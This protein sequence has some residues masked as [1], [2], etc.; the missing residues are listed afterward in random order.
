[1]QNNNSLHKASK[2][3]LIS[4]LTENKAF[5]SYSHVDEN[6]M[7][8][9]MLI[10]KTFVHLDIDDI[11][12]MFSIYPYSKIKQVW[13]ERLVPQGDHYRK[14]NRLLAWMYFDIKKPDRYLNRM[15]NQHNKKLQRHCRNENGSDAS[16]K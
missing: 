16:E 7:P 10:E 14:L 11:N 1:M 5:W 15:I 9:E 6:I 8:D 2:G 3:E 12:L 13:L 4:K